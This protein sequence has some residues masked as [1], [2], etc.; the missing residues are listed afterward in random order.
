MIPGANE[1]TE[2]SI[3]N[4][5][6]FEG[7]LISEVWIRGVPLYIHVCAY[8]DMYTRVLLRVVVYSSC[9]VLCCVVVY[10]WCYHLAIFR[11]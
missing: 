3:S 2:Y 7:V 6:T 10:R 1:R 11:M 5:D 4:P 9:V 8:S